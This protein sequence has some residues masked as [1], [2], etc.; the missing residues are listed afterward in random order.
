MSAPTL[1]GAIRTHRAADTVAGEVVR[2]A[3]TS[4]LYEV[5]V[6][7]VMPTPRPIGEDDL[8]DRRHVRL[9]GHVSVYVG[10]SECSAPVFTD[11][12]GSIVVRDQSAVFVFAEAAA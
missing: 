9:I 5:R 3:T 12:V 6:Q 2:I 11:R 4:H 10:G 8:P 7:M 1:G